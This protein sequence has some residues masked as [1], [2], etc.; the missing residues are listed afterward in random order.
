VKSVKR[1]EKNAE[2]GGPKY[3]AHNIYLL[4]YLV[5]NISEKT[6]NSERCLCGTT[7]GRGVCK[8]IDFDDVDDSRLDFR[9]SDVSRVEIKGH[10]FDARDVFE[11]PTN[12]SGDLDDGYTG[13]DDAIFNIYKQVADDDIF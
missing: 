3:C 2:H 1:E 11:V 12:E 6:I 5:I 7:D 4:L 13:L 8:K 9:C 10:T